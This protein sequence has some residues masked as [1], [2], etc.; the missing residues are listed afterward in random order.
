MIFL[1]SN[2]K[3]LGDLNQ[4][5]NFLGQLIIGLIALAILIK[6]SNHEYLFDLYFPFFKKT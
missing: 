3:I 1:K 4:S 6:F 2:I 5:I